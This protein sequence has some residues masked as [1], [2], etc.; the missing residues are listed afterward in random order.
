MT[1]KYV[2]HTP[3]IRKHTSYDRDFWYTYVKWW[4]L[5]MLFSF[6]QNFEFPGFQGVKGQ[7]MAPK[8]QKILSVSLQ[9][10]GNVPH[11]GFWCKCIKWMISPATFF[12]FSKFWFLGVLGGIK[13]QKMTQN[14]QFQSVTLFIARTVDHIIKIFSTQM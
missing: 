10:P 6:F 9:I 13:G 5:Q 1:K 7:K 3:Y 12:I 4:H 8:W 2:R 14:Y 11:C